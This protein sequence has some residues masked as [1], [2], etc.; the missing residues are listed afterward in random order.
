VFSAAP[1]TVKARFLVEN[2][3]QALA[4]DRVVLDD[5]NLDG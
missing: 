5:K 2:L 4:K 3:L 1:Q